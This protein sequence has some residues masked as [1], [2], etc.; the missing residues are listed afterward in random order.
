M[1][2]ELDELLCSRYPEIFRD[3]HADMRTTCMCWG[4]DCGDG[5]FDLI[6]VLC[7]EIKRRADSAGLNVVASQVKEKYGTLRFYRHGGDDF[8]DGLIWMAEPLSGLVCEECGQ[9]GTRYGG[10]VRT[11]CREHGAPEFEVD[12]DGQPIVSVVDKEDDNQ[13]FYLPTVKTQRWKTLARMLELAIDNDIRRN[14]MPMI[15]IDDVIET[16]TLS[17]RWHGGDDKGRAAGFF[18]FVEAFSER[19]K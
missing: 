11:R 19:C 4:F 6:D 10:W 15:F 18:R 1:R 14:G 16:E 9:P 8:V 5:W 7:V 3:R 17:F 12:E 13:V 2:K